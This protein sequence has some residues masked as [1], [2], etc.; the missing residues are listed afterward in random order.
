MELGAEGK[1]LRV[2]SYGDLQ[3]LDP[4]NRESNPEDRITDC[5]FHN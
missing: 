5:T 4:L 1:I 3:V 2:R